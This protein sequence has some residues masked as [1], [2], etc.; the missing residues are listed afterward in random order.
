MK[1]AIEG[2]IVYILYVLFPILKKTWQ[3][4]F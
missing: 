2:H 3:L 1:R 4:R